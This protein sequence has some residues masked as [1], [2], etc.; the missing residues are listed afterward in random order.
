MKIKLFA[1]ISFIVITISI[2]SSC[3]STKRVGD[4]D[5]LLTKNKI[6]VNGKL[7]YNF[8]N[9]RYIKQRANNKFIGLYPVYLHV[10]NIAELDP[11]KRVEKFIVEHATTINFMNKIFSKKAVNSLEND[12]VSFQNWIKKSGEAP[13]ILDENS[14]RYSTEQLAQLYKSR[15]YFRTMTNSK[16]KY[17]PKKAVVTYFVETGEPYF[18]D[19]F[20]VDIKSKLID[21]IYSKEK[22]ASFVKKGNRY[23]QADFYKE[24]ERL[25]NIFKNSGIYNFQKQFISFSADTNVAGNNV[26]IKM[27]ISNLPVKHKDKVEFED[28]KVYTVN[29]INI[30]TDNSYE[31]INMPISDSISVG[32][33]F[34]LAKDKNEFRPKV[35]I[36]SIYIEPS[37]IYKDNDRL[38]TLK[39]LNNLRMFKIIDLR[40]KSDTADASGTGL[41]GEINLSPLKK[42]SSKFE[43]EVTNSN[44]LLGLG[45]ASSASFR[46]KNT[47][48]G[49]EIF[50]LVVN[51]TVGNQLNAS[52]VQQAKIFNAYQYG[53]QAS[54][55]F[56]RFI[57]PFYAGNWIT[58]GMRPRTMI[59]TSLNNQLNIGLSK[60]NYNASID[61]SW[62]SSAR[63]EHTFQLYN[64]Q[65]IKYLNSYNDYFD[66][67]PSEL[68]NIKTSQKVYIDLH[69]EVEAIKDTKEILSVMLNDDNFKSDPSY[70]SFANSV[71]RYDRLTQDYLI[72]SSSYT[73]TYNSQREDKKRSFLY[74]KSKVELSG[75][76]FSI[77]NKIK[78][79]AKSTEEQ[80]NENKIIFGL[81]YAQF[82][83]YDLD[84][85]KYWRLNATDKIAFRV[86]YGV[87]LAFGNSK[88][89]PFEKSYF[90]GGV[91]DIRAW[92]PYE[93]GPGGVQDYPFDYSYDDMKITFSLEYRVKVLKNIYGATFIDAGNI[94]GIGGGI[95]DGNFKINTFYKQLGVGIGYGLRYDLSFFVFRLDF[96]YKMYDP[97]KKEKQRFV[98][99]EQNI[100]SPQ[101]NFAVGYPF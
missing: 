25:T 57:M 5:F 38:L 52:E 42:N 93:L 69:P 32:N 90:S 53:V 96:G 72:S 60:N 76:M 23:D 56:P 46:N 73:Y 66:A 44:T 47:F 14:T 37:K 77:I 27:L 45:F 8:E 35:L 1:N 33:Y 71:Q 17:K 6:Y 87:S 97:S 55:L 39:L 28:Y 49:A 48:G 13:V 80:I 11:E 43:F 83:K 24:Q 29:K 3:I 26:N 99:R 70:P 58:K 50:D 19:S 18:I 51:G 10:Y 7:N 12:Y 98:L 36:S 65:Y 84:F 15:G 86:L 75:T 91:N 74:I 63:K 88:E 85:R 20:T 82:L 54:L 101:I 89:I 95:Y 61:Y 81:P 59:K 30:H 64:I 9:A 79:L 41:I 78:P 92:L 22:K 34:F 40:F 21:S 94:W 2:F 67:N 62:N 68:A 16:T 31:N 100:L 4:G